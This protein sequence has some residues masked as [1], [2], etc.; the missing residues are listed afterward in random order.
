MK[1]EFAYPLPYEIKE[2]LSH[3]TT[4]TFGKNFAQKRGIFMPNSNRETLGEMLSLFFWDEDDIS[5]IQNEAFKRKN[6]NALSGFTVKTK[7][8]R[9][10]ADDLV[11][12]IQKGEIENYTVDI[13]IKNKNSR[14][15]SYKSRLKYNK[16]TVGK[17]E[18]LQQEEVEFD[19]Y[20]KQKNDKEWQIEVDSKRSKDLS[21][22]KKLYEKNIEIKQE[23][24]EIESDSLSASK[25]IIFLDKLCR[26][27]LCDDWE[28]KDIKGLTL[29]RAKIKK[30]F[31]DENDESDERYATEE[32]KAGITK[33]I[34]AGNHLREDPFVKKSESDGYLFTSMTYLFYHKKEP[35]AIQIKAEFKGNPKVFEISI[36]KSY[37]VKGLKENLNDISLEKKRD[38]EIRTEFWNN[39]FNIFVQLSNI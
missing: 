29:K 24:T 27:G 36:I 34:L 37:E 5:E 9:D 6:I 10:L 26:E 28:F 16:K 39:A 3:I 18:L 12:I 15:K 35:L 38:L 11:S 20:I 17:T 31:E 25:I 8:N 32:E 23:I 13:P 14:K 4:A 1:K 2:V 19:F 7:S 30:D 22:I 21:I 33:A